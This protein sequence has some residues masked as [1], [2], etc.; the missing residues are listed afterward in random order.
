LL[1]VLLVGWLLRNNTQSGYQ[2]G[3]TRATTCCMI[4]PDVETDIQNVIQRFY[5]R[6]IVVPYIC[7]DNCGL[8]P[9]IT[10]RISDV[11]CGKLGTGSYS[12]VF[13]KLHIFNPELFPYEKVVFIDSDLYPVQN[14][15]VLFSL[16]VPAGWIE[17]R[18]R[19]HLDF[20]VDSWRRDRGDMFPHGTRIDSKFTDLYNRCASDINGSLLVVSPNK[21]EYLEMIREL[22]S[23]F[24]EWFGE[25]YS[26]RGYWDGDSYMQC[27]CLPEQNYLTQ[28]F[29]GR[30]HSIDSVFCSWCVEPECLGFTF[31]GITVKPWTLQSPHNEYTINVYSD[32]SVVNNK[33]SQRSKWYESFNW[34][35][36]NLLRQN[37]ELLAY[38]KLSISLYPFDSWCPEKSQ[39]YTPLEMCEQYTLSPSQLAL[40]SL[41]NSVNPHRVVYDRIFS[42]LCNNL[43]APQMQAIVYDIT[44]AILELVADCGLK[45]DF[46]AFGNTFT[47]LC[48]R[49]IFDLCDDDAD[50]ILLLR[51][52][53]NIVSELI[54]RLLL[55]GFQVYIN[56][57]DFRQ[58][59]CRDCYPPYIDY[60]PPERYI[61]NTD[62]DVSEIRYFNVSL[63][64]PD[65]IN[66]LNRNIT[67]EDTRSTPWVDVFLGYMTDDK[68]YIP[69]NPRLDISTLSFRKRD[70]RVLLATGKKVYTPEIS[71]F[72]SE[73]Y[74]ERE[75]VY[76]RYTLKSRH[77]KHTG[78]KL[79]NR[80]LQ[81]HLLRH[82]SR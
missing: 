26:H 22:S 67:S 81:R 76:N 65:F 3:G 46:F 7:P 59:V 56:D 78:R 19:Q 25:T 28:H 61:W 35:V 80:H 42:V 9:D 37:P 62:I 11:S 1:S 45:R 49:G 6:V 12:K 77:V 43:F 55:L 15:D 33:R 4:T 32:F 44:T 73:Y 38:L 40:Y 10:I 31:A 41:H 69:A 30:W 8:S 75:K 51:D 2:S 34:M 50:F 21:T 23:P 63:Y 54:N 39:N 53:T 57:G 36:Y 24:S 48:Q 66:R 52:N 29:S 60:T 5:D 70:K 64:R 79:Y 47:S 71:T 58:V 16:D 72:C 17:H 14:F 68:V 18:R 20:G 74:G 13:T 27:Y 82:L